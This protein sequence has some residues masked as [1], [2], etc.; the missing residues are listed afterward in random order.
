MDLNFYKAKEVLIL[1]GSSSLA[2]RVISDLLA[3]GC[4]VTATNRQPNSSKAT[5]LDWLALDISKTPS[6]DSFLSA[7][8]Q[9]KFDA[10]LLFIGAPSKVSQFASDYVQTYFT[11]TLFLVERLLS[12]LKKD[13]SS[14]FIHISSRSS[15]YPS[16][17]MLYSAVKSGLNAGFRS[18]TIGLDNRIK[19]ISVA[20]GLI[21]GSSMANDMPDEIRK[22]HLMRSKENLLD[23]G[24]FSSK[25][26]GLMA[27]MD[28]LETGSIIEIGPS[29]K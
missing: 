22:D 13:S 1:G 17:D 26:L 25:I 20:T 5:S 28:N 4:N 8:A 21:L 7:I 23:V 12:Q 14:G 18:M 3:A 6:I 10:I 19:I 15:I 29:Y 11:N 9:R 2:G 24:A 16:R 27:E